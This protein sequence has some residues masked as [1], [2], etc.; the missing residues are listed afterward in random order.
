MSTIVVLVVL[1]VGLLIGSSYES[2][3][4]AHALY[5]TNR[6][7]TNASRSIWLNSTITTSLGLGALILVLYLIVVHLRAR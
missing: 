6:A 3:H 5:K 2:A 1:G 7:R 4:D